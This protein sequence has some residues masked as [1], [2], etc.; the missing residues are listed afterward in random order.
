MLPPADC[1]QHQQ[2]FL[3]KKLTSLYD[4]H[5]R[6]DEA[7]VNLSRQGMVDYL[8]LQRLKKQKLTL[9]DKIHQIESELLPDIIA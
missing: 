8:Q 2:D 6:L 5:R 7:V 9:K 3:R 1:D 4:E